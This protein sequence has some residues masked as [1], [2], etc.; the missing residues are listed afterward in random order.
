MGQRAYSHRRKREACP[1]CGKKTVS[2]HAGTHP[3]DGYYTT[4]ECRSCKSKLM[5]DHIIGYGMS[6]LRLWRDG[7]T[8]FPRFRKSI[9]REDISMNYKGVA[10]KSGLVGEMRARFINF[11]SAR[12]GDSEA[13]QCESGYAGEWARRFLLGTEVESCDREWRHLLV[14]S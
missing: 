2:Y 3:I 13:L 1:S 9:K 5:K 4:W 11:M 6:E 8:C 12:W 7:D 14:K 10:D